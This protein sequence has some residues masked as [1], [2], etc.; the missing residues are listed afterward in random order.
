[1]K[2]TVKVTKRMAALR[3][4]ERLGNDFE[5]KDVLKRSKESE[6]K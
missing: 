4:G 3:W 6:E 2:L 1:M 5:Q